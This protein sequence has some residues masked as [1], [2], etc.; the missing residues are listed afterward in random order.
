MVSSPGRF[1]YRPQ[2]FQAMRHTLNSF[3]FGQNVM[4]NRYSN[5]R[6]FG[7]Y[8]QALPYLYH[9]FMLSI[10]FHIVTQWAQKQLPILHVVCLPTRGCE[11][12][13][14]GWNSK[15][16]EESPSY[17]FPVTLLMSRL[18]SS[19]N[20]LSRW[21]WEGGGC[22]TSKYFRKP[23]CIHTSASSTALSISISPL[24]LGQAFNLKYALLYLV[25]ISAPP[26]YYWMSKQCVSFLS[27]YPP[28]YRLVQKP[29]LCPQSSIG[30]YTHDLPDSVSGYLLLSNCVS[31]SDGL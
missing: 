16:Q 21:Y 5:I 23:H 26:R 29:F 24:H 2:K 22:V 25:Y 8:L 30:L 10:C 18:Y 1:F 4:P 28:K 3:D 20:V 11:P 17:A 13:V 14:P 7:R 15:Q 12:I 27:I 31:C 19:V 9:V 6:I